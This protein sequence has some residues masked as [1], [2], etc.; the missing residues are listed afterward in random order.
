MD[1]N[2]CFAGISVSPV[3]STERRWGVKFSCPKCSVEYKINR[4]R[5]Q[6]RLLKVRCKNCQ[7]VFYIKSASNGE[8]G[9]ILLDDP[10]YGENPEE[11]I[12]FYLQNEDAI[13]PVSL[14]HLAAAM[15]AQLFD[16]ETWVWRQGMQQWT[17]AGELQE[18]SGLFQWAAMGSATSQN[19]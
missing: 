13:G 11:E 1:E 10:V 2:C 18:L 4:G 7:S 14:E 17:A 12:W 16:Q 8:S 15:E 6:D 3:C 9:V 5:L 19:Y